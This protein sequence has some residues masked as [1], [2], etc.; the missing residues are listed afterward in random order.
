M[1]LG[2]HRFPPRS[3]RRPA[4]ARANSNQGSAPQCSYLRLLVDRPA[5]KVPDQPAARQNRSAL[6][7]LSGHPLPVTL[8]IGGK[9][10]ETGGTATTCKSNPG[11]MPVECRSNGQRTTQARSRAADE[12]STS[13]PNEFENLWDDPASRALRDDL[14][15]ELLDKLM[16]TDHPLPRQLSRS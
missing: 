9:Q 4:D 1:K 12:W 14:R 3:S 8:G 11:R 13:Y 5:G 6:G 15:L 7:T 2:N 10:C 16:E